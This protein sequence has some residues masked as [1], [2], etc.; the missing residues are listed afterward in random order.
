[1]PPL[2]TGRETPEFMTPEFLD[3]Y[4]VAVEHAAKLGLKLCLYD[5]FWFPSGSAGGL[6]ARRHPEAL[7]KRLDMAARDVTG[8]VEVVQEAPAGTF[9]GAV[10][11]EAASKQRVNLSSFVRNGRLTWSAPNG[12]W[13]VMIYT[14]VRDG[15][16]GL[17]D[18]LSPEAVGKFIELT[19]QAY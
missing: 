16:D 14:C 6:L 11:M 1:R 4:Q 17:V 13:K 8:P 3:Q 18:Y 5:E 7:S 19:Y 2:G 10:A 9:M 12:R 15:G